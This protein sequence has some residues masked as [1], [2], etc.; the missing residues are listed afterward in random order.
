LTERRA[1]ATDQDG[2]GGRLSQRE[3]HLLKS[4]SS[5]SAK[6]IM[7][8]LQRDEPNSCYTAQTQYVFCW[9]L[10]HENAA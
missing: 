5:L 1:R 4:R 7:K 10:T 9:C 8:S 6:S 3:N 2:A